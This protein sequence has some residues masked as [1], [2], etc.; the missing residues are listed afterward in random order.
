GGFHG[1]NI[2]DPKFHELLIRWFQ[3]GVFSPVMRL[4][5]NRDPQIL[6]AQPYRDG[7][8][9]CPTGAPNEVWSYGEEVCEVLTGCLALREKLKPY[10][11]ALMEETHKHNTPVMRP[12][13]FEFPEQ[14]TSWTITDQYCFGPDLLIAPVM[15]E[16]MR[17][18]D[19]WLPEGETWTDLAT[20]ESYS[21]GQ[22]LHYATPLNRIPV[23]IRE[24][25]QYR[26]LLNL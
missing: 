2:H 21:G 26:S 3:W 18:R 6:P 8:A 25:G 4:H 13:F 5:G 24:G 17:E 10:I 23:F 7:I 16:G 1:G 22:T 19:V 12:L 11:K 9:Q 15:H 14:E 20:G